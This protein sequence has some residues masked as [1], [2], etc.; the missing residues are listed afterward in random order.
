MD[1]HL[2]IAYRKGL[3][4]VIQS[5][6][7][8]SSS[9]DN[10]P[11][12]STSDS[13]F[14]GTGDSN[15]PDKGEGEGG[16]QGQGEGEGEESLLVVESSG[17]EGIFIT[18]RK[19]PAP[20]QVRDYCISSH[21]SLPHPQLSYPAIHSFVHTT[22]SRIELNL[23]ELHYRFYNCY[24]YDCVR[25]GWVGRSVERERG[26]RSAHHYFN[27][28]SRNHNLP[29]P[30]SPLSV[31]RHNRCQDNSR[32]RQ[33]AHE[34]EYNRCGHNGSLDGGE[35]GGQRCNRGRRKHADEQRRE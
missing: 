3:R 1:D 14:T 5:R 25:V 9:Q 4:A 27:S 21:C 17:L 24:C 7:P 31:Y 18:E 26:C 15:N 30:Y 11:F 20:W 10:S 22:L 33:R 34:A 29:D 8:A 16:K 12:C 28:F 32:T 6:P 23:T 35:G 2:L 13:V 19:Q